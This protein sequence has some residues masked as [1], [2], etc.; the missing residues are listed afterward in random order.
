MTNQLS[1]V[2]RGGSWTLLGLALAACGGPAAMNDAGD[3]GNRDVPRSDIVAD[4]PTPVD[5]RPTPTDMPNA[6]MDVPD[7]DSPDPPSDVPDFDV[8]SDMPSFDS[9]SNDVPNR[10]V[11]N[12]DVANNDVPNADV[13]DAANDSGVLADSGVPSVCAMP[14]AGLTVPMSSVMVMTTAAGSTNVNTCSNGRPNAGEAAYTLNIPAMTGLILSTD[15]LAMGDPVVTLRR[16][17][18][19]GSAASEILCDDDSGPATNSFARGIVP[20]GMYTVLVDSFS[21]S[22]FRLNVATYAPAA[23]AE[24]A[25]A[26][27]LRNGVAT[28]GGTSNAGTNRVPMGCGPT[29]TG[30]QVYYTYTIPANTQTTFT[31]VRNGAQDFILRELDSCAL[32]SCSGFLQ[33]TAMAGT[34]S[35]VVNNTSNMPRTVILS[36]A[37]TSVDPM[38]N[39][40]FTITPTDRMLAPNALCANAINIAAGG[41]A[42]GNTQGAAVTATTCRINDGPQLFYTVSVPA[43]RRGVL[44][45]TR[46]A[47]QDVSMRLLDSCGANSCLSSVPT[48]GAAPVSL[49]VDN[50]G[51]AARTVVISVSS[52][53]AVTPATFTLGY[54]TVALPY[55][56]SRMIGQMCDA[57]PGG[58]PVL[59]GTTGDDVN[60]APAAMPFTFN[61]YRSNYTHMSVSSN[62]FMQLGVMAPPITPFSGAPS[63]IHPNIPDAA[64]PNAYIAPFWT[65]LRD[66]VGGG[67]GVQVF[68]VGAAP[69]RRFVLHWNNVTH[70]SSNT[71]RLSFQTRLYE[72]S[73]VIETVYCTV[74]PGMDM[75]NRATGSQSTIGIENATGTDGVEA[76]FN[77][78]MAIAAGVMYRFTPA[79]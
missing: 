61:F 4:Q 12:R 29:D 51:A 18:L 75:L 35:P 79:P 44:S 37:S 23:N 33:T 9:A 3:G 26:I 27:A 59:A 5:D 6:P 49:T 54:A 13:R 34:I 50:Q 45:L 30:G 71:I 39:A 42:N 67:S 46:M 7:F 36:V 25:G 66:V 31:A 41:M 38:A 65:D 24:C 17:C 62:G 11:P 68:T 43:G 63:A 28:T 10:D 15:M 22:S 32:A 8:P 70:F 76:A 21:A 72:T 74:T 40:N 57:V 78:A 20:A 1:R 77:N 64:N 19:D 47:A 48:A 2:L 60:S 52:T 69:N 56:V 73:N 55:T 16:N 14:R 53:S 58:T